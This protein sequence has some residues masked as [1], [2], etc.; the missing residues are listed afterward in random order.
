MKLTELE[1][2]FLVRKSEKVF[3]LADT[4][5]GADGIQFLCPKCFAAN[6]GRVGTHIIICWTPAVPPTVSPQPG[7]WRL[8]GTDY[9]DLNLVG[10]PSSSVKLMGGCQAHF[11]VTNGEI[12]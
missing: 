1:P 5:D 9:G 7:R 2:H 6:G 10:T 11:S 3:R 12:T 4:I 8:M